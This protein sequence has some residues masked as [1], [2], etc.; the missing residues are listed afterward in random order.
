[1]TLAEIKSAVESGK[2]V[3]W[4][5]AA[6]RVVRDDLGQWLIVHRANVIGLTHDDGVTLNGKPFEFYAVSYK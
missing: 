3:Y 4:Q 2:H 5:N 1:M 6:Y